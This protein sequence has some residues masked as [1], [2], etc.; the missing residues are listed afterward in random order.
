MYFTWTSWFIRSSL[1]R[2]LHKDEVSLGNGRFSASPIG[3]VDEHTG[4]E[5]AKKYPFSW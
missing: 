4:V 5:L 2:N 1:P 3:G